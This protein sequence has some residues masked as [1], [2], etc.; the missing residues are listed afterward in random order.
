MSQSLVISQYY[1]NVSIVTN[2]YILM[3]EYETRRNGLWQN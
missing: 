3:L 2:E 1:I